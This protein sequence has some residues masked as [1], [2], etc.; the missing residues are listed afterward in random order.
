MSKIQIICGH[1]IEYNY[2]EYWF[3]FHVIHSQKQLAERG[4]GEGG[5]VGSTK[6]SKQQVKRNPKQRCELDENVQVLPPSGFVWLFLSI[7]MLQK[8]FFASNWRS[9]G[10][11]QV[12]LLFLNE[13]QQ[14]LDY[15]IIDTCITH[16]CLVCDITETDGQPPNGCAH[17]HVFTTFRCCLSTN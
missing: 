11:S 9:T 15:D 16:A 2:K 6:S 10:C 7:F 17:S 14:R 5:G 3:K 13:E 4:L 12:G 8:Y 1:D